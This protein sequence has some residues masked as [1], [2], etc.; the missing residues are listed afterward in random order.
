MNWYS[1]WNWTSSKNLRTVKQVAT[2][3]AICGTNDW[4]AIA[5]LLGV[6]HFPHSDI[7]WSV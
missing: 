4:N 1:H 3:L 6:N 5:P 7:R 2:A